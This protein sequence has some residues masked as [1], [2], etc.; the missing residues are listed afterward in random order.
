MLDQPDQEWSLGQ[1]PKAITPKDT[2]HTR[3]IHKELTV[4]WGTFFIFEGGE[5]NCH[6]TNPP[7]SA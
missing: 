3:Y 7:N 5:G 4:F 6:Q 1:S 2:E